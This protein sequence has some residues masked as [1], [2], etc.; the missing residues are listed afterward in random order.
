LRASYNQINSAYKND[1]AGSEYK[2]YS[3]GIGAYVA[4]NVRLDA[5]LRSGSSTQTRTA[6]STGFGPD[7]TYQT[8]A[9]NF[10]MQLTYR[11]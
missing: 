10:G 8:T 2:T 5:V 9:I 6:Y 3:F 4:P 7:Y 11:Y 1:I